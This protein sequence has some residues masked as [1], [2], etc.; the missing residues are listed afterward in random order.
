MSLRDEDRIKLRAFI[1]KLEKVRGR[2]TE[3]VSVY[4][5]KGY[6]LNKILDHLYQ[7][8]GT[9]ENIKSTTT[10]KNVID[11]L[12]RMIQHLKLFKETPPN[13]LAVFSG[14][15]SEVEGR[16]DI[17]VFSIEPPEP[18]TTRIYRCDKQFV[19]DPLKEMLKEEESYG[20]VAVDKREATIGVLKGK[21]VVPLA[22]LKSAVPGKTRA[23]GQ[24]LF[25]DTMIMLPDGKEVL[26][27][28]LQVGEEVMSIDLNTKRRKKGIIT[29][30]WNVRKQEYLVIRIGK[31][32]LKCSKD[33]IIFVS[34]NGKLL[35][36]PAEKLRKSMKIILI[37]NGRRTERAIDSI[38]EVQGVVDLIDIS[39]STSCFFA[40]G[41]LVHNS[42]QR[43]ERVREGLTKDFYREI[44]DKMK[45]IFYDKPIK[46]IIIGGP[47]PTKQ[48][49]LEKAGLPENLKEKIVAVKDISYTDEFGLQEL[50]EKSQDVLAREEIAEEKRIMNKFLSLL[51]KKPDMVAYGEKEVIKHLKAGAVEQLLLSD[52]I[53]E[54]EIEKLMEIAEQMGTKLK[55]ISTE[56][57]E[58]VQLRELGGYGA[59]LR[60]R[61]E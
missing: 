53:D 31:R 58:G 48:E 52:T 59:I 35:E 5:P 51:S 36:I 43:F 8:Q 28:N 55:V 61:I 22:R 57:R 27:T 34:Q 6:S 23:G 26:I 2:H 56:T 1:K 20:L 40:N 37:Q 14:N 45:E 32:I 30:Y 24:C 29:D 17:E 39:V 7:E 44:G 47:G 15:I 50:L 18:I 13:G 11:A 49:F 16:P 4:I 10:R 60:Y 9:A 25:K 33:H 41:I 38:E 12:E 54:E 46:G 3:L 19:L 42:A 21:T